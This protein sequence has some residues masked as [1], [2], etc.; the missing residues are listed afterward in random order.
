M[1]RKITPAQRRH[2]DYL[3]RNG[4]KVGRIY[5]TRLIKARRKE[6]QRLLRLCGSYDDPTQWANVIDTNLSE[7][8]LYDWYKGLYVDAGVPRAKSQARDLSRGKAEPSADYWANELATFAGQRAGE[9]IVLVEGTFRESLIN[10]VRQQMVINPEA[11]VEKLAKQIFKEYQS[12]EL[13]QARRIAQTETMIG[14]AD[15]G[16]VAAR[17]LDIPFRKQWAISGIGNT[18]ESH[19]V[20]DG[21]IVDQEEPFVLPDGDMMLYPHDGSMGASAGEIINCACDCI[22]LNI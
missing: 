8:Y 15:A 22:R 20:M 11:G 21:I 2:M 6:V 16:A 13:W 18:R 7:G 12:I 19:E 17:S 14:L 9:N 3:R 4:L 1:R 5:E 10:L